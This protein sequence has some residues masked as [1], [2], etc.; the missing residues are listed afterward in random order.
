MADKK[1]AILLRITPDLWDRLSVWARDDLRSV[2][3][4]IEYVLREAVRRRFGR[5][6]APGE[7][8]TAE[9]AEAD[10]PGE[11]ETERRRDEETA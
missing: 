11:G 2:N 8:T 5:D 3:A 6:G 1:K 9:A 4:Q 7:A 10:V